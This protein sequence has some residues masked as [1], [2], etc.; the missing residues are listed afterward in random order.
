[1]PSMK[2]LCKQNE[3]I[4]IKMLTEQKD[5]LAAS[6]ANAKAEVNKYKKFTSNAEKQIR[7]Y[8]KKQDNI[9][10]KFCRINTDECKNAGC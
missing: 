1:M 7:D 6:V 3:N 9:C 5:A 2:Q 8:E 4:T 10:H